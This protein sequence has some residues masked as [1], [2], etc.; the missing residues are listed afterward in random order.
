MEETNTITIE[1]E[2]D[3]KIEAILFFKG[4]PVRIADLAKLAR[5]KE[6]DVKDAIVTLKESLSRRGIRLMEKE[7][8][9]LLATAP[10]MSELIDSVRKEELSKDIGKA[11]LETLAIILYKGPIVRSEIDYIRG[12]NSAFI[13]R[14]LMIRGLIERIVNPKDQ[15][16][17]LYKPTFEILEYLGV[18]SIEEI[19]DYQKAKDELSNFIKEKQDAER[20]EEN[21]ITT[22][23]VS[24]SDNENK[25]DMDTDANSE[26]T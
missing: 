3:R 25:E 8:K 9:V 22:S 16:S 4:E 15:R 6:D 5:V 11:G 26:N 18:T 12:V 7:D 19:P 10:E 20:E 21:F 24:D 2:L 1:L 13:L 23:D 14:N 17:F